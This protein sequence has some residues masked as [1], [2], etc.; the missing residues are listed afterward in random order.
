[1]MMWVMMWVMMMWVMMMWVMM[2]VA[3]WIYH[4]CFNI[5]I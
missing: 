5:S 2:M 3:T 4:I 1:M